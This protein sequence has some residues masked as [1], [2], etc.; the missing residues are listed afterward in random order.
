MHGYSSHSTEQR[1]MSSF[2]TLA[3]EEDFIVVYPD[4]DGEVDKLTGETTAIERWL[5]LLP[6]CQ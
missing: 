5:V 3:N 2:E 6:L 4:G 1:Q